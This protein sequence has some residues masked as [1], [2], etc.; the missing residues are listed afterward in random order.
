MDWCISLKCISRITMLA[1]VFGFQL[2]WTFV[3]DMV[4]FSPFAKLITKI[5]SKTLFYS[6]LDIVRSVAWYRQTQMIWIIFIW[7]SIFH[8]FKYKGFQIILIADSQRDRVFFWYEVVSFY[9]AT[10]AHRNKIKLSQIR[11]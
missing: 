3:S 8:W 11:W 2:I 9:F 1:F 10:G 5:F 4:L 7:I 6:I